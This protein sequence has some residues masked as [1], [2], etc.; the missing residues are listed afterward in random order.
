[1]FVHLMLLCFRW[2]Q[3]RE[4][5]EFLVSKL[6]AGSGEQ[7]MYFK[8]NLPIY[9]CRPGMQAGLTLGFLAQSTGVLSL[10]NAK[11][12]SKVV[13]LP[14]NGCLII[15]RISLRNTVV[16]LLSVQSW[17]P[18]TTWMNLWVF[19]CRQWAAVRTYLALI[20][21]PPHQGLKVRIISK[22]YNP[23]QGPLKKWTEHST[24]WY[25][26]F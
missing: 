21:V 24:L 5:S 12:L 25:C 20:R 22:L 19:L 2:F 7:V 4:N 1:M 3:I 16:S 14:K 8:K 10:N 17:S 13:R 26:M 15:S 6:V 11:S 9:L 18:R 23:S